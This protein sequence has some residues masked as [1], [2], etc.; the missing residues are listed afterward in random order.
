[1]HAFQNIVAKPI[2][3]T[4][5]KPRDERITMVIDKGL[6]ISQAK[7]LVAT[8]GEY[9]DF[10]KIGFGS[11]MLY[12]SE[13]LKKKIHLYRENGVEVYP[14]GTLLEVA[15]AQGV[16]EKFLDE[17]KRIGFSTIEVSDGTAKISDGLRLKAIREAQKRGFMVLTE[18][19]KKDVARDLK[20]EEYAEGI[21][22][23]LGSGAS[24][25]LVEATDSGLGIG[26]YDKKGEVIEDKLKMILKEVKASKLIFEAPN[27]NQQVYLILKL[28]PNVNLGNIQPTDA[29]ALECLRQGLRGDTL[30]TV[31]K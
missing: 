24:H 19:G 6:G 12:D 11:C 14:G 18:V 26:I 27:K 1:M 20:G 9:I 7:D 22:K 30:K 23:D 21:K 5:P 15:I 4:V 17:A 25:V 13:T 2:P 16:M 29:L 8:A 28:G 10:I 31:L 3:D